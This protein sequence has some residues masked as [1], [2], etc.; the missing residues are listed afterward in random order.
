MIEEGETVSLIVQSTRKAANIAL[1]K[2]IYELDGRYEE[3]NWIKNRPLAMVDYYR[4][5]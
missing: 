3:V 5:P 1:K 4:T 2:D